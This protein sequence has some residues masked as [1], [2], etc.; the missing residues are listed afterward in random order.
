MCCCAYVRLRLFSSACRMGPVLTAATVDLEVMTM[1]PRFC[2]EQ[3]TKADGTPKFRPIDDFTRSGC[4]AATIPGEKLVYESL[5]HFLAALRLANACLGGSLSMWKADIDSAYRRIPV[6]PAHR[7]F[8]WVAF[9]CG[10]SAC[11]VQHFALPFGSVASVHHWNRVGAELACKS[12]RSLLAPG[13]CRRCPD[14]CHRKKTSSPPC[15]E[16]SCDRNAISS[17]LGLV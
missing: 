11:A 8:A 9:L 1:S 14:C 17:T 16:V 6:L 5:D 15:A 10:G 12:M 7:Q 3:G 2:L 13:V 4:N